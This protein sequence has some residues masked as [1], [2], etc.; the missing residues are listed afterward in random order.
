MNFAT[1]F[2]ENLS[3]SSVVSRSRD[4]YRCDIGRLFSQMREILSNDF[5]VI[6]EDDSIIMNLIR[7]I[8]RLG[9]FKD[10]LTDVQ[11]G[12]SLAI[13]FFADLFCARSREVEIAFA[14]FNSIRKEYVIQLTVF[15]EICS[16]Q[17][18][19]CLK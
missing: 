11:M 18:V 2:A 15:S 7:L 13:M 5:D 1:N 6:T 14:T 4:Q 12:F 10:Y 3:H 17:I 16:R 19:Q 9:D 8:N